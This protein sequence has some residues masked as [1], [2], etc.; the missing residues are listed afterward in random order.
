MPR[1]QKIKPQTPKTKDV[2][3]TAKKQKRQHCDAPRVK[4]GG[5]LCK[6]RAGAG[7]E[8]L[9]YGPCHFHGGTLPNIIKAIQKEIAYEGMVTYGLP[10]DIDPNSALLAELAR[11]N[12][13]VIW[14]GLQ[15]RELRIDDLVFGVSSVEGP[16]A[17]K[18]N[19]KVQNSVDWVKR[20]AAPNIW[21][22]LYQTERRHLVDVSRF[23]IGAGIAERQVD[24]A[25]QQGHVI[26]E[27]IRGVV[28]DLNIDQSTEKKQRQ[29]AVIVRKHLALASEMSQKLITA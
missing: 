9:G 23:I 24:I 17:A 18:K 10:I 14:L 6:R 16:D 12:G 13:H 19:G 25:E 15:V 29:L 2:Y 1:K 28:E 8:H 7:T 21:L 3:L 26:A 20:T 11:V 5:H 4:H 22:Q 27:I